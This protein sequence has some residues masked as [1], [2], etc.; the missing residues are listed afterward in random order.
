MKNEQGL[1]LLRKQKLQGNVP[2][3][4]CEYSGEQYFKANVLT[5]IEKDFN[6]IYFSDKKAKNKVDVAVEEFAKI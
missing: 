6:D 5:K 4:E 1:Q 2:C 3:E